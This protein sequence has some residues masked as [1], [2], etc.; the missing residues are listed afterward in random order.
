MEDW[1][2]E[3]LRKLDS[4]TGFDVDS[5]DSFIAVKCH[6]PESFEVS[7]V[8]DEDEFRVHYEGWHEHFDDVSDAL[9][10]FG[11]GLLGDCRLKTVTRGR[12]ECSWTLQVRKS[13]QWVSESK[14]ALLLV[15]FWRPSQTQY[16]HNK[17]Q[18][19]QS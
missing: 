12:E 19:K 14:T 1:R 3:I 16:R 11:F 13:G 5:Q 4:Y 7:F 18:Q 10:C 2:E 9:S 8:A 15:P 6:N 17:I